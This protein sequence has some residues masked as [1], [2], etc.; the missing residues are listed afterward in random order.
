MIGLYLSAIIAS[1]QPLWLNDRFI[2]CVIQIESGGN[3]NAISPAG[4]VGPLQFMP[5]T[6]LEESGGLSIELAKDEKISR[7]VG[8]RYFR[9]IYNTLSGWSG[10]MATIDECLAA[11][12]GGMGRLRRNNFELS[13]MPQ[14]TQNYVIKVKNLYE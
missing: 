8:K 11:Y 5:E 1:Y 12:N 9:R 13:K 14:E 4:A 3:C 10:R 6:W 7:V 2:D